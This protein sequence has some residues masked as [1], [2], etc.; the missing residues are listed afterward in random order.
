M[1]KVEFPSVDKPLGS[2]GNG[3][4]F[5]DIH[6]VGVQINEE[7]PP[8]Y[9]FSFA[10]LINDNG[11][12]SGKKY[13][14]NRNWNFE[15]SAE[16][17]SEDVCPIS[18]TVN[19]AASPDFKSLC[20][21]AES[22]CKNDTILSDFCVGE[23]FTLSDLICDECPPNVETNGL[24]LSDNL[25]LFD[26]CL[27]TDDDISVKKSV[28]ESENGV[29]LGDLSNWM[30]SMHVSPDLSLNIDSKYNY[31]NKS[32]ISFALNFKNND[33]D[34]QLSDFCNSI[35]SNGESKYDSS[36][37]DILSM[38]TE[39]STSNFGSS[40][41]N[42]GKHESSDENYVEDF[43]TD[44]DLSFCIKKSNKDLLS[45]CTSSP[46][47]E[48]SGFSDTCFD[49]DQ[50]PA[51]CKTNSL[52]QNILIPR[53]SSYLFGRE[54][55]VCSKKSLFFRA[56][57]AKPKTD[58]ARKSML[59]KVRK[60]LLKESL[61]LNYCELEENSQCSSKII[62]HSDDSVVMSGN[63]IKFSEGS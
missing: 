25:N 61:C 23:K 8:T 43:P 26:I 57:S 49:A 44:I 4:A 52:I 58:D 34:I 2:Y 9:D 16:L 27:G 30:N 10:S 3:E 22:H 20:A 38:L 56:I 15:E 6:L 48:D 17:L 62:N 51:Q 60:Q 47:T 53:K 21:L 29:S 36:D 28:S 59:S 55:Q 11:A 14:E 42:N 37:S 31:E 46:E 18:C 13:V 7:S 19:Q 45:S 1:A 35:S 50:F 54:K 40:D 5:Q 39:S 41:V 24:D 63:V 32:P 33:L 12:H